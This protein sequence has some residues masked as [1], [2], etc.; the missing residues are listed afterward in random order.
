MELKK[1]EKEEEVPHPPVPVVLPFQSADGPTPPRE[2]ATSGK[3]PFTTWN[4]HHYSSGSVPLIGLAD[5]H[6]KAI[7]A[8]LDQPTRWQSVNCTNP[9]PPPPP[10]VIHCDIK[11]M[12]TVGELRHLL[13]TQYSK[14]DETLVEC[15]RPVSRD[16]KKKEADQ[17][18]IEEAIRMYKQSLAAQPARDMWQPC[19][20]NAGIRQSRYER[21]FI[22]WSTREEIP[23]AIKVYDFLLRNGVECIFEH[24]VWD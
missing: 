19:L 1:K 3:P 2:W 15:R 24:G 4:N 17:V 9:P 12:T 16:S 21:R 18:V 7:E 22:M 23:L 5:P 20:S 8:S 13:E 14:N 11:G 10:H 6:P